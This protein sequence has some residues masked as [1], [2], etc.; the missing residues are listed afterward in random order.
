M[1]ERVP[2]QTPLGSWPAAVRACTICAERGRR[3]TF[4][5]SAEGCTAVH[6]L[7]D[8]LQ[9]AHPSSLN[10]ACRRGQWGSQGNALGISTAPMGSMTS[11][12]LQWVSCPG[13]WVG[14]ALLAVD[15][16]QRAVV[17]LQRERIGRRLVAGQV[18]E[19]CN[20]QPPE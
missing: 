4:Y 7:H 17:A 1:L 20:E 2:R 6:G 9:R 14:G 16:E 19:A 13:T 15:E 8:G 12:A 18:D 5:T 11:S 10:A 3:I